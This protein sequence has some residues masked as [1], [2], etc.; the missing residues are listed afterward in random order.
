MSKR[1]PA[2]APG[3]ASGRPLLCSGSLRVG[4]GFVRVRFG[5][6]SG[7][8]RA[9]SGSLRAGLDLFGVASDRLGFSKQAGFSS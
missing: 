6:A 4:F 5:S 3:F 2:P 9:C 7:R 1:A 8:L